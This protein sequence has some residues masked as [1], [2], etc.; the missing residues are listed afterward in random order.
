M[1]LVAETSLRGDELADLTNVKTLSPGAG[2]IL[3]GG[4]V[5]E[6][7]LLFPPDSHDRECHKDSQ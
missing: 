7:S 6:K 3:F 1:L 5:L 2:C 4:S